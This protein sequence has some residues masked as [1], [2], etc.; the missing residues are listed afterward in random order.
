MNKEN[1]TI[2]SYRKVIDIMDKIN[3]QYLI[4][5]SKKNDIERFEIERFDGLRGDNE[6]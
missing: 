1:S 5:T 4:V 3:E 6:R 2:V